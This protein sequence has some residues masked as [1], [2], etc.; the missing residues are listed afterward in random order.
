VLHERE[1]SAC[2]RQAEHVDV[3]FVDDGNAVQRPAGPSSRPLSIRP[4]RVGDRQTIECEHRPQ[5]RA[6]AVEY[7]K[8]RKI[9][10]DN[11][12]AREVAALQCGL[13]RVCRL[14]DDGERTL[15]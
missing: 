10:L 4:P 9:L 14:F 13:D 6:V 5:R 15:G 8:A 12:D 3:V 11:V 1:R 2:G 7:R